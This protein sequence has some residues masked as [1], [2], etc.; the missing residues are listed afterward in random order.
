MGREN[1]KDVEVVVTIDEVFCY[2]FID[3]MDR[4]RV[5]DYESVVGLE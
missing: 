1:V 3:F 5:V 4:L 2:M